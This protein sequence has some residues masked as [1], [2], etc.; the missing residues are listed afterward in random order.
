VDL[1]KLKDSLGGDISGR[2]LLC[3]GPGHSPRD[4]SLAVRLSADAPD[5]LLVFSHAGDD[6]RTCRDYVRQRLGL[7]QCQVSDGQDRRVPASLQ[8]TEDDLLRIGRATKIWNEADDPRGTIGEQYLASRLLGLPDNI[9]GAVLRFHAACPWRDENTGNTIRVPALIAAFRSV[10]DH[11]ITAVHRIAL[12]CDGTKLGRRM[13]GIVH[14]SAVMLQAPRGDEIVIGEGIE[15][16]MAAMQLGFTPAWALG[17]VGAIS[18]FPVLEGVKQLTVLGEAGD[19]SAR[20][21]QFCGRRWR[22]AGRRV[23]VVMP[24]DGN[25]DLNDELMAKAL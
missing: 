18:F 6:W 23:R 16:C 14:R 24:D 17:S 19:A 3:P 5:G 15:T 2:Q 9:A 1:Q 7:P 12:N 25:S 11:N 13:L 22:R 10:D 21:V 20:A 4:R 8:R